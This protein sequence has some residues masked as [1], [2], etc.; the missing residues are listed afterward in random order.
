MVD[1]KYL[2]IFLSFLLGYYL[3]FKRPNILCLY[4]LSLQPIVMP[5]FV[6]LFARDLDTE[7][8]EKLYFSYPVGVN[9]LFILILLKKLTQKKF[10]GFIVKSILLPIALIV[11]FLI[12]QG[13]F[14]HFSLSSIIRN[15]LLS[16]NTVCPLLLL[17]IE[18][19]L[20]PNSIALKKFVI[21]VVGLQVLF[22]ILNIFGVTA[23]PLLNQEESFAN[24][25]ISGT[26][27]RYNHM[28]NYLTTLYLFITYDYYEKKGISNFYFILLSV[29]IGVIVLF[30]GARM[31]L[32]LF[33]F[34][35]FV[36]FFIYKRH[37]VWKLLIL[38]V[39][40]FV[41]WR[42]IMSSE[43]KSN[44]EA[45]E[46]TGVERN[47]AGLSS[48]MQKD[49]DDDD[50][51]VSL[52]FYLLAFYFNNPVIGNGYAYMGEDAYV[53]NISINQSAF[54]ADARIAYMIVEYGIL[55]VF[56]FFILY[57]GIYKS[58]VNN[59]TTGN[60]CFYKIAYTYFFICTLTEG[61]FFDIGIFSMLYIY[62]FQHQVQPQSNVEKIDDEVN[63]SIVFA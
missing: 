1:P 20:R 18:K 36:F 8:F 5:L 38:F 10:P 35:L 39:V 46:G 51:T 47:I 42:L 44:K 30:S 57:L 28:T 4:W 54:L 62:G 59:S 37:H 55:G 29:V 6:L 60:K 2:Y 12:V 17:I 53:L 40:F 63:S 15:S 24:H 32:V 14:T 45:D 16:F 43:V 52:S 26:F 27:G 7:S 23:Y 48:F 50:S 56:L 34:T 11:V 41:G 13:I 21:F 22:C 19:R 58:L 49:L 61:G 9:Y 3:Y 33:L 31:S 25:L